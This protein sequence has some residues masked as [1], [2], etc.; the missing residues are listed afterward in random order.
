LD[1]APEAAPRGGSLD[2]LLRTT[3]TGSAV[4][5]VVLAVNVVTGI[6]SARL[7]GPS[8][9][10]ELAAV[11]TIGVVAGSV[12]ALSAQQTLA[13]QVAGRPRDV[14]ALAGAWAVTLGAIYLVAAPLLWFAVPVLFAELPERTVAF[15][16]F[17]VLMIVL[18]FLTEMQNGVLLGM[19]R[20]RPYFVLALSQPILILTLYGCLWA[21]DRFDVD[22]VLIGTAVLSGSV[23]LVGFSYV[24]RR[25]GLQRA[26]SAT[27]RPALRYALRVHPSSLASLHASRL[28]LLLLPA[29]VGAADVG[30]YAVAVSVVAAVGAISLSLSTVLLPIASSDPGA[31]PRLVIGALYLAAGAVG[32]TAL[33]IGLLASP[34]LTLVYGDAFEPVAGPLRMMLAGAT[35]NA[36]AMVLL[37]GLNAL[38]RPGLASLA[39]AGGLALGAVLMLTTVETGGLQ[40]AAVAAAAQATMTLLAALAFYRSHA[41]L[42]WRELLLEPADLRRA[43]ASVRRRPR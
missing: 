1:E 19:Q 8:G 2:R 29:L 15:G 39:S 32:A 43:L 17:F 33:V 25:F 14:G 21:T 16:R 24:I 38:G 12:L 6:L 34:L 11:L 40:A 27:V 13:H 36:V 5:A 22:T 7:L 23:S 35:L 26:A 18:A 20:M 37:V 41:G 42:H 31:A 3:A 30:L 28:A 4:N 10:G 9:R